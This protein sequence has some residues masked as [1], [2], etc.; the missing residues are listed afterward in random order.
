MRGEVRPVASEVVRHPQ[1]QADDPVV[2]PAHVRGAHVGDVERGDLV[3]Q[4]LGDREAALQL[5]SARARER[6][7]E[8]ASERGRERERERDR[9]RDK[10]RRDR[11]R[12]RERERERGREREREGER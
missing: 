3:R 10:E 8:R 1:H 2:G 4:G 11:G 12:D 7:S 5:L 9:R 6:D